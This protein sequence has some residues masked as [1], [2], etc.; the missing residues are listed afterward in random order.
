MAFMKRLLLIV[1]CIACLLMFAIGFTDKQQ[2]SLDEGKA[3]STKPIIHNMYVVCDPQDLCDFSPC[4]N[5]GTCHPTES[6]GTKS[7]VCHCTHGF[8]GKNCADSK[9][10]HKC[11]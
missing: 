5:G 3:E 8:G 10:T 4:R 9:Y 1:P 6:D 2:E 7:F 11:L